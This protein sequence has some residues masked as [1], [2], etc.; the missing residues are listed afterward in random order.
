[1]NLDNLNIGNNV[2]FSNNGIKLDAPL[3][4][5]PSADTDINPPAGEVWSYIHK[6]PTVTGTIDTST[7]TLAGSPSGSTGFT[8]G[9]SAFEGVGKLKGGIVTN[10]S[11]T[12]NSKNISVPITANSATYI[13]HPSSTRVGGTLWANGDNF[14]V[15]GPIRLYFVYNCGTNNYYYS[16]NLTT[17]I[18]TLHAS[19][20][21][22]DGTDNTFL[23]GTSDAV[24][25]RSGVTAGSSKGVNIVL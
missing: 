20:E 19:A 22:V 2:S 24:S 25:Y 6:Y 12:Y 5:V 7:D 3:K 10:L 4:F 11:Q 16:I 23:Q 14:R 18:S 1:M 21:D 15:D 17:S 13:T 9:S 8:L